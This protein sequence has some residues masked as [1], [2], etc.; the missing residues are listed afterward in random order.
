MNLDAERIL[1][2]QVA[3]HFQIEK[4]IWLIDNLQ[5]INI[6]SDKDGFQK[7][8]NGF[9]NVRSDSNWRDSYFEYFESVKDKAPSFEK[10]IMDLNVKL[11]GRIEPSFSS[12]MLATIDPG[13][14]I[15]DSRVL[16]RLGYKDDWKGDNSIDNAN[17]IYKRICG[18][19]AEYFE[20]AEMK[21]NI[22]IFDSYLPE[23][24]DRISAVKKIDYLLWGM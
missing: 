13:R 16:V 2:T 4:Y 9:W 20:T 7:K 17:S 10:I 19:Y 11:K 1:K 21:R 12:K 22:E 8:Y 6:A 24:K 5:N 15:W 18:W 23:Y 3:K 14:P